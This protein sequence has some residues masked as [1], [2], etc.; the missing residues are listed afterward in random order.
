MERRRTQ[1]RRHLGLKLDGVTDM[2]LVGT[3]GWVPLN[4]GLE[5]SIYIVRGL[6]GA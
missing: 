2:G 5:N 6:F 1:L 4:V 3:L